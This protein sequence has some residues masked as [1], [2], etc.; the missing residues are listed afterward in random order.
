MELMIGTGD[1]RPRA[2]RRSADT[3]DDVC[4]EVEDLFRFL[5]LR[6]EDFEGEPAGT[7][8]SMYVVRRIQ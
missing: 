8:Q 4:D 2:S 6:F 7:S 3:D 5:V 1:R